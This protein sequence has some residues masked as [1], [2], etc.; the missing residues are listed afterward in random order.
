MVIHAT[1]CHRKEFIFWIIL[2]LMFRLLVSRPAYLDGVT[3]KF[4]HEKSTVFIIVFLVV[5]FMIR[6]QE[7]GKRR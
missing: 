6:L 3:A 4:D 2:C 1:P 5:V 7:N